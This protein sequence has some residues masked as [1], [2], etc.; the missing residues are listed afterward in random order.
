MKTLALSTLI[1]LLGLTAI[2]VPLQ[3]DP[4]TR[5][6]WDTDYLK[7]KSTPSVSKTTAPKHRY[8]IITPQSP[9][10]QVA[11][12]TVL[13]ITLWRLRPSRVT[14]DKEV[15]ILKHNKDNAR[16]ESWTPERIPAD[17]PLVVGQRVRLSIE[18]ART[19]YLYVINR[20]QYADGTVGDPYLIFPSTNLRGGDNQ[21]MIGRI[22]D[23]PALE[24]DPNFFTLDPS[25]P[26]QVGEIISVI[27]AP[28]PLP[29][30]KIGEHEVQLPNE[31]VETW[32]KTWGAKVGRL[33]LVGGAGKTW[34]R[35]EKAA[36]AAKTQ[37][38][39]RDGPSPQTLYY[40]PNAKPDDPLLVSLQLRYGNVKT[41][42]QPPQK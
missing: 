13:G 7:T 23:L 16:I 28:K 26:D 40:R 6:L 24:D 41:A 42:S 31:L 20:E 34:K 17:T 15:R 22:I 4:T 3:N 32:E 1:V 10:Q 8:R 19:G 25:R 39:K 33:E 29:D 14:D 5:R 12:D 37:P 9:A 21:V 36:S 38:L 11:G 30:L 18:A 2:A 27:V 35:E